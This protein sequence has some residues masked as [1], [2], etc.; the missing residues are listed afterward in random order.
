MDITRAGA[1]DHRFPGSD[2]VAPGITSPG[3]PQIR[4]CGIPGRVDE[5][6]SDFRF[7]LVLCLGFPVREDEFLSLSDR[8]SQMPHDVLAA[9]FGT[10]KQQI[11]FGFSHCRCPKVQK[12]GENKCNECRF[13][14][15]RQPAGHDL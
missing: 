10:G 14:C 9:I 5:E 8:H 11:V 12:Q 2:R 13:K 6:R 15:G 3:L 1:L 7:D 4:A